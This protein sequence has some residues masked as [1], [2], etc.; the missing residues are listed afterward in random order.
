MKKIVFAAAFILSAQLVMA[1]PNEK[2]TAAM[3]KNLQ[4]MDAAFKN[5]AS[6]LALA[7]QF[8]RIA[9]AEK[10]EWLAYYYAALFQVNTG[11]MQQ[12]PSA[13]DAIA[14]KASALINT[15]DSLSANN[16]EISCVKAMIA[17]VRMLV[18]PMQRYM[19]YGPEIETNLEKAKAQDAANPRP[20]Y[21]KG[22]NLK[23]T[24]EQFGGGCTTA[25]PLLKIAKEKYE[26]FKAASELHPTW[27]LQRVELLL[28][29]CK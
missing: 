6:L 18:N 17:I 29:Q 13:M 15:A 3:K 4:T 26:A 28:A 1:Q 10:T 27:G 16:S 11:F 7:N 24:P 25:S 19:Q 9:V 23:N 22:E 8:E 21:L 2:F 5:P 20:Y 14:D 12:D